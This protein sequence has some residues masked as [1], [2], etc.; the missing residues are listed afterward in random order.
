VLP[1]SALLYGPARTIIKFEP[2]Q[3]V[4]LLVQQGLTLAML[5]LLVAGVYRLAVR[6]VTINGG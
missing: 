4:A 1:F 6:R 5:S 3:F 2:G